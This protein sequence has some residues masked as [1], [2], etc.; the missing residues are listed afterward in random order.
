MATAIVPPTSLAAQA[1]VMGIVRNDSSGAP[2]P[3]VEVLLHG[4]D[5]RA[6]TGRD[7]RYLLDRLPAGR[8]TVIVRRIGFLPVHTEVFLA[9]RDTVRLHVLLHPSVAVLPE[10]DV[11]G[12]AMRG[13]GIGREA[14]AERRSRGG[15]L[16]FDSTDMRRNEHR[17]LGDMARGRIGL[18]VPPTR[19]GGGII[20]NT[21]RSPPCALFTYYDGVPRGV[22]D[23]REF[24]VSSLESAEIYHSVAG[25]P[26]EY[27]GP[28]ASCGIIL[29]WS[30]RGP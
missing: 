2:M 23:T 15:G 28:N 13:V 11:A 8:R 22:V 6:E 17:T 20:Y 27:G 16:F 18:H 29:L 24:P 14:F 4:T 1:V 7:G 25:M 5:R 19:Y 21:R 10:V 3:G 30:R 9:D 12:R 26:Q